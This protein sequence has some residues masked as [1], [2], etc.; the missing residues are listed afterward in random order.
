MPEISFLPERVV[1]QLIRKSRS[2]LK[3]WVASGNFPAP[4][5]LGPRSLG[6]IEAEVDDWMRSRPAGALPQP[7]HLRACLREK[8][9]E[10]RDA[11]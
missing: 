7:G 3:R 2:T 9:K 8:K 10:E 4:R 6:W 11:V 1:L 5:K